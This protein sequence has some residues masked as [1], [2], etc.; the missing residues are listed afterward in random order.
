MALAGQSIRLR[1]VHRHV[2]QYGVRQHRDRLGGRRGRQLPAVDHSG[3]ARAWPTINESRNGIE[4]TIDD[5]VD[6]NHD[7]DRC[8]CLQ[9]K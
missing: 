8:R 1:H 9:V 6:V 4:T 7:A 2:Y 3:S 5:I